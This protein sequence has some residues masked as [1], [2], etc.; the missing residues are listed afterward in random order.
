MVTILRVYLCHMIQKLLF[1][2]IWISR[3]ELV[4]LD[5]RWQCTI[6]LSRRP[7]VNIN[8]WR[9]TRT[10]KFRTRS[11]DRGWQIAAPV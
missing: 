3:V 7:E 1:G 5:L 11:M 4:I 10:L 9:T 8:R 2:K 6:S